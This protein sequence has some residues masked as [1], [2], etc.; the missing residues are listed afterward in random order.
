MNDKLTPTELKVLAI[1]PYGARA[2]IKAKEIELRTGVE[3]RTIRKI[4]SHLI[5]EHN[6][7]IGAIRTG[8]EQGY[9][10]ATNRQEL[11]LAIRPLQATINDINR[12]I[13]SLKDNTYF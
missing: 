12:R 5:T 13:A 6:I 10:I 7:K 3:I 2:P 1:I 9:F 11:E 4:I 8:K